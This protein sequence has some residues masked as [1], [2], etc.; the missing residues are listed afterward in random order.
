MDEEDSKFFTEEL[1]E[2]RKFEVMVVAMIAMAT[3][4]Y[5]DIDTGP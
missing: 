4:S 5:H 3:K 1:R 2:R